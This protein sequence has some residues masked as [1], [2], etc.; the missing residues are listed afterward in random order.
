MSMQKWSHNCRNFILTHSSCLPHPWRWSL[1]PAQPHSHQQLSRQWRWWPQRSFTDAFMAA[2]A[3]SLPIIPSFLWQRKHLPCIYSWFSLLLPSH[4][5]P[6]DK[7]T[8]FLH[9]WNS[10]AWARAERLWWRKWIFYLIF[11][12]WGLCTW[13][14]ISVAVES[15]LAW[16]RL[17]L[18]TPS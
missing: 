15:E 12:S 11:A 13:E 2:L 6:G 18:E 3:N 5:R 16:F 4:I 9:T 14:P 17:A 7:H 1:T 10:P 8:M